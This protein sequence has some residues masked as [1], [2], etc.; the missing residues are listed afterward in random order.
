MKTFL[1]NKRERGAVVLPVTI[2]AFVVLTVFAVG[3]LWLVA[4]EHRAMARAQAWNAALAVAEAGVE[5][6]M[7]QLN[8]G[9]AGVGI[10]PNLSANSWQNNMATLGY[11]GPK[12]SSVTN[13]TYSGSYSVTIKPGAH[14]VVT[15]TGTVRD[16]LSS[17]DITRTVQLVT[18]PY[19]PMTNHGI[20]SITNAVLTGNFN[21]VSGNVASVTGT[22]TLKNADVIGTVETGGANTPPGPNSTVTGGYNTNF[23]VDLPD[24]QPPFTAANAL[25]APSDTKTK[26]NT[27]INFGISGNYYFNGTYNT[28]DKLPIVVTATNVVLYVTGSA[29]VPSLTVAPGASF[30]LFVGTTNTS[31][32]TSVDFG[33]TSA[34]TINATGNPGQFLF[35]G[36]PSTTDINFKN[37]L[38]L[39]YGIIYAPE[40]SLTQQG[41]VTVYGS[42]VVNNFNAKGGGTPGNMTLRDVS[43]SGQ[44]PILYYIA[45]SWTEL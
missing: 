17:Q 20:I 39:F 11:Y 6:G 34:D 15:A 23:Y 16:R 22:V 18:T 30:K 2:C 44:L 10:N 7:A 40:A 32:S 1:A 27:S 35:F 36:L 29:A 33:N 43:D 28:K 12:S 41:N 37:A 4:G 31:S 5:E 38:A 3:H 45:Q 9:G 26:S 42:M 21:V 25:P 13:G 14:P 24:V 19:T 8:A